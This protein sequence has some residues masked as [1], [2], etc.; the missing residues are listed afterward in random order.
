MRSIS[1]TGSTAASPVRCTMRRSTACRSDSVAKTARCNVVSLGAAESGRMDFSDADAADG[2]AVERDRLVLGP[3]RLR[4]R[5]RRR[6][7]RLS[8]RR[9]ANRS[10]LN[11][12]SVGGSLCAAYCSRMEMIEAP[13]ASEAW[14]RRSR[15]RFGLRWQVGKRLICCRVVYWFNGSESKEPAAARPKSGS[16]AGPRS[17]RSHALAASVVVVQGLAFRGGS[18]RR[19]FPRLRAGLACRIY[20]G[21]RAASH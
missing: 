11:H 5:C 17:E 15:L 20:L 13:S 12:R 7:M 10:E 6:C 9:T 21:R 3:R 19:R 1:R 18:C 4:V 8:S 16:V 14:N 2:W